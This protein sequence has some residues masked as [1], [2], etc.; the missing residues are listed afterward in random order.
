[1][2]SRY[3]F[4]LQIWLLLSLNDTTYQYTKVNGIEVYL[5]STDNSLLTV[6]VGEM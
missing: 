5:I 6:L 4:N 1:M 2:S 3:R